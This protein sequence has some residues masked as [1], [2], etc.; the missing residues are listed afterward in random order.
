MLD[1]AV[2]YDISSALYGAIYFSAFSERLRVATAAH[3]ARNRPPHYGIQRYAARFIGLLA[4]GKLTRG[5]RLRPHIS[6][7]GARAKS[8]M[9]VV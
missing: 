3:R 8:N 9:R 7:A 2:L 5:D 6:N 4:R 1:C